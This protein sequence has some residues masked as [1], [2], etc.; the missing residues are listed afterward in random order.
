MAKN[1]LCTTE[2]NATFMASQLKEELGYTGGNILCPRRATCDG[3]NCWWEE[4]RT[5][6]LE[7]QGGVAGRPT[8]T[9][10]FYGRLEKH[11]QMVE[12]RVG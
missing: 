1:E 9:E 4:Q 7:Q 12:G 10:K 6:Y 5:M 2:S 8:Q 3:E 11:A